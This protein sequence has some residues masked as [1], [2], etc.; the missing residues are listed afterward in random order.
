MAWGSKE[1][2]ILK[3][4]IQEKK[5]EINECKSIKVRI[6]AVGVLF[7]GITEKIESSYNEFYGG[8]YLDE[9]KSIDADIAYGTGKSRI[10]QLKE[11]VFNIEEDIKNFIPKLTNLI[12][13]KEGELS[14]LEQQYQE[15]LAKENSTSGS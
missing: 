13:K 15:A 2:D 4:K 14:N 11:D 10:A 8:G 3:K 7:D 12:T 9:G 6:T 5:E 1:S